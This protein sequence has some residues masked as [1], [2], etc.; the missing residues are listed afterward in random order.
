MAAYIG[1]F[2][3]VCLCVCVLHCSVVDSYA[4]SLDAVGFMFIRYLFMRL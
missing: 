1:R 2:L 4:S 3:L